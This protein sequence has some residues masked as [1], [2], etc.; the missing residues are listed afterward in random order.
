MTAA[1]TLAV[2]VTVAV[3]TVAATEVAV[4]GNDAHWV[5][6]G[7]TVEKSPLQQPTSRPICAGMSKE[8]SPRWC[9]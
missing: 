8:L 6:G 7:A 5:M 1:V 4:V 9:P 2:G 3:A